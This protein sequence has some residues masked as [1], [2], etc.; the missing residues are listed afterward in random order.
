MRGNI[1]SVIITDIAYRLRNL[2]RDTRPSYPEGEMRWEKYERNTEQKHMKWNRTGTRQRT[3][4]FFD[5]IREA[6][7]VLILFSIAETN[8]SRQTGLLIFVGALIPAHLR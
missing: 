5:K 6:K 1:G 4:Q 2:Y 8:C 3:A 7:K